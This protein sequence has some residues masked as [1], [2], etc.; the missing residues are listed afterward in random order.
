MGDEAQY[1]ILSCVMRT[2]KNCA[3]LSF[4]KLLWSSRVRA[5]QIH[6][7]CIYMYMYMYMYMEGWHVLWKSL[8]GML[9]PW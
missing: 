6:Y 8:E 5:G 2:K 3:G 4:S 7:T 1:N 9:T